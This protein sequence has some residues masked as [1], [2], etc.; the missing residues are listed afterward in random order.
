MRTFV[1]TLALSGLAALSACGNPKPYLPTVE[2]LALQQMQMQEFETSKRILFGSVVSVLQDNGFIIS[3]ADFDTGVISAQSPVQSDRSSWSGNTYSIFNKASAFVEDARPGFSRVRLNFV[4][5]S[6]RQEYNGGGGLNESPVE[7]PAFYERIFQRI[8]EAVFVREAERPTGAKVRPG[9]PAASQ[10]TPS[11]QPLESR[12]EPAPNN[13]LA[14]DLD[15][16]EGPAAVAGDTVRYHYSCLLADGTVIFDSRNTPDARARKA[17]S[18]DAPAALGE[19]LIGA[20]R[21][22]HRRIV[23]PPEKA[24]GAAGLPKANIPPNATLVFDLSIVEVLPATA[25]NRR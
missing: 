11:A 19:G 21:G 10:P 24:Y 7:T 9:T 22:M 5:V 4:E 18:T 6:N 14:T 3:S 12:P 1:A 13:A 16:G 2:P 17:G 20:R 25:G 23:A 15:P 8:R